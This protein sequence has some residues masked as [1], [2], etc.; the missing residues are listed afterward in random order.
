MVKV[1]KSQGHTEIE[2]E[3]KDVAIL[4]Y[5]AVIITLIV[6][7]ILHFG[8][9]RPTSTREECHILDSWA[10]ECTYLHCEQECH[11]YGQNEECE[12]HCNDAT[13]VEYDYT[14]IVP[15]KCGNRTDV[16]RRENDYRCNDEEQRLVGEVG[17]CFVEDNCEWFGW[18]KYVHAGIVVMLVAGGLFIFPCFCFGVSTVGL[19]CFEVCPCPDGVNDDSNQEEEVMHVKGAQKNEVVSDHAIDNEQCNMLNEKEGN[20]A[21]ELPEY[22]DV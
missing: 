21:D 22:K 4:Y 8:T 7:L 14:V 2:L 16:L 17:E 20:C 15:D 1:I 12:E 13:G 6:G 5:C 10:Q 18:H 11:G 3:R 19:W 9:D